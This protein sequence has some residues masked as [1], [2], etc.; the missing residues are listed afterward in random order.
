MHERTRCR[1]EPQERARSRRTA[2]TCCRSARC[3]AGASSAGT[4]CANSRMSAGRRRPAV[5]SLRSPRPTARTAAWR[6]PRLHRP[7]TSEPA[8]KRTSLA[9]TAHERRFADA[10][11]ADDGDEVR[12]L[13]APRIR[14]GARA[15]PLVFA[16][17]EVL[18]VDRRLA[19]RLLALGRRDDGVAA[20]ALRLVERAVGGLEQARRSL[21][22]PA[23]RRRR[24]STADR[25]GTGPLAQRN[26]GRAP[27][28]ARMRSASSRRFVGAACAAAE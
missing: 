12:S 10:G 18:E 23:A 21:R 11:F 6:R 22:A 26:R 3:A 19:R 4:S 16:S 25:D 14:A 27:T 1:G 2:R 9:Q 15:V 20:P 17:N 7:V 13:A 24:R 28:V 5:D 8:H